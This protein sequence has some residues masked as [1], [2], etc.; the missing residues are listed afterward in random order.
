MKIETAS[1]LLQPGE[2][3]VVVFTKG[4]DFIFDAQGEGYTG[5]WKADLNQLAGMQKVIVYYRDEYTRINRVYIGAYKG[6]KASLL[7]G[8]LTIFFGSLHEVGL[9]ETNWKVFADTG[10]NPVAYVRK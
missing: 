8:R 3:A 4:D 1:N 6:Y 2:S 7:P 9:V 5:H 10:Q